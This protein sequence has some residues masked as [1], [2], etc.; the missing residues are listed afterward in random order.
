MK[1]TIYKR[2]SGKILKIVHKS[3]YF[4]QVMEFDMLYANVRKLLGGLSPR[5]RRSLWHALIKMELNE[6][7][8][9]CALCKT[10]S[11]EQLAF[12]TCN[13]GAFE[14]N[15]RNDGSIVTLDNNYWLFLCIWFCV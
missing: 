2:L 12:A 3:M 9:A 4:F 8:F 5:L 1:I 10:V 15:R 14:R 11:V 13:N 6:R 7:L